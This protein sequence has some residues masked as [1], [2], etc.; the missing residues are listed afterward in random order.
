MLQQQ[1][2]SCNAGVRGQI[3]QSLEANEDSGAELRTLRR[4]LQH[5]SKKYTFLGTFQS[6][7]LLKNTFKNG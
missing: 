4:F 7:Y 1:A 2:D 6:K 5:F 3:P